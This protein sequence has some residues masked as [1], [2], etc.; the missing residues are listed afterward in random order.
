MAW[1]KKQDD[2]ISTS[3][4]NGYLTING[5]D[6]KVYD[7]TAIKNSLSTGSGGSGV[8]LT[9][10]NQA[11]S[12]STYAG[13]TITK[14][15]TGALNYVEAQM[16][17]PNT[18]LGDKWMYA[19]AKAKVLEAGCQRIDLVYGYDPQSTV[20]ASIN[21]PVAG[22]Y[23]M[24][25]GQLLRTLTTAAASRA[26]SVRAYYADAATQNGK[27]LEAS[28]GIAISLTDVFGSGYEP[29]TEDM[30]LLLSSFTDRW[31]QDTANIFSAKVLSLA[32]RALKPT[33]NGAYLDIGKD[34]NVEGGSGVNS[35]WSKW[36]FTQ[37]NYGMVP[38]RAP[39]YNQFHGT[40]ESDAM[41][42]VRAKY[43]RWT[44]GA[45]TSGTH[46]WG[47]HVFEGWNNVDTYRIT[48]MMGKNNREDEACLIVFSP[49]GAYNNPLTPLTP[50][51]LAAR[52]APTQEDTFSGS[53]YFGRI[54]IG[55]DVENEGFLF[56][57][58]KL[59]GYGPIELQADYIQVKTPKTPISSTAAGV[60]GTVCWD[61]NYVYVCVDT[62]TWK[63][64]AL[65]TW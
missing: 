60:K 34:G 21:S 17:S 3:N 14:V 6:I 36:A 57:K 31:F 23:Y 45:Q 40:V 48:M 62:N 9:A 42:S 35:A 19:S 12:V 47:G 13:T 7:D 24:L 8:T 25:S 22:T 18:F 54:R 38:T 4:T 37:Y 51:Q 56:Q 20:L 64:T 39:I 49:T 16:S 50:E 27:T 28:K 33:L 15:G 29:T 32:G 52:V 5:T 2:I 63:R 59:T 55:S 43:G 61:A 58:S 11:Y 41:F 53:A 1:Q 10:T 44:T 65:S 46:L 26:I 30:D